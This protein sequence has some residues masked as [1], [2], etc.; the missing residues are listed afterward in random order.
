MGPLAPLPDGRRWLKRNLVAV[1]LSTL[2]I[3]VG[4]ASAAT[5]GG[6]GPDDPTTTGATPTGE[7]VFPVRGKHTYGD[8]FGAG[9]HHEGQ[10]VMADCGTKLVD[11]QGGRVQ[12]AK[13]QSAAGNYVVIDV[14]GSRID[15][16]YMHLLRPSLFKRG[17]RVATGQM[18]GQVGQTG[19]ASACHLHFEMWSAPGYY[20]G[21]RPMPSV[22]AQL[23][24]WDRAKHRR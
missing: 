7:G 11:A 13:S 21:G 22:T 1:A 6:V 3:G 9:R 20:E 14:T 4:A 5:G 24:A 15:H 2:T 8:G 17:Q 23:K 12:M 10:D 16:V 19:N 18:I